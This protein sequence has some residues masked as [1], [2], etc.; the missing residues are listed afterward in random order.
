MNKFP[1]GPVRVKD[2]RNWAVLGTILNARTTTFLDLQDL[3]RRVPDLRVAVFLRS[4]VVKH[5]IATMRSKILSKKC[6]TRVLRNKDCQ[7]PSRTTVNI[8]IFKRI[9]IQTLAFDQF[10]LNTASEL[11]VE[12]KHNSFYTITYESLMG[13]ESK[14]DD[15]LI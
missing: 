8:K 4:N 9:L 2:E 14:I 7:I 13:D 15:L 1:N 6:H 12:L 10:M 11:V 3:Q 5:V